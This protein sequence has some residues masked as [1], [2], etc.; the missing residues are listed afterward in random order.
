VNKYLKFY[1]IF[2]NLIYETKMGDEI[3]KGFRD[4]GKEMLKH[5]R[6]KSIMEKPREGRSAKLVDDGT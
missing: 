1:F 2:I 6:G 5:L 4:E 3:M